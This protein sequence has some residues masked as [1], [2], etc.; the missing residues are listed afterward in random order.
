MLVIFMSFSQF[1]Q[2]NHHHL[3][4]FSLISTINIYAKGRQLFWEEL[5]LSEEEKNVCAIS[6]FSDAVK[7]IKRENMLFID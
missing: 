1:S 6:N 4:V 2:S 7:N 3:S 5:P